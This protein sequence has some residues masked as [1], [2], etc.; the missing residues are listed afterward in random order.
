MA[1]TIENLEDSYWGPAPADATRL[2]RSCH[3][4]RKKNVEQ[5]DVED[6]RLLIGQC[7]ALKIVIPLA[8][9]V[10]DND[11]MA[12]GDLY[13]GDLLKAVLETDEA[14]WEEHPDQKQVVQEIYRKGED[15][16]KASRQLRTLETAFGVFSR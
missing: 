3:E 11:L 4:L 5:L 1:D 2:V 7:I 10:L 8:L 6:M 15:M 16:V 13:P 14:Y 12:E 9:Q